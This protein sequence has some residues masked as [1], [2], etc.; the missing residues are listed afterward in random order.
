M[1]L[2]DLYSI[3][4]DGTNV[5]TGNMNGINVQMEKYLNHPLQWNVCLLYC[6]ELPLQ[7]LIKEIDGSTTGPQTYGEHW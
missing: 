6:N 7:H 5:N 4:C 3:S 2:R 1:K